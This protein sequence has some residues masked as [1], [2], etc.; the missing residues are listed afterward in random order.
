MTQKT[1]DNISRTEA[2]LFTTLVCGLMFV[3]VDL[4]KAR[5]RHMAFEFKEQALACLTTSLALTIDAA[6]RGC[7]WSERV[8]VWVLSRRSIQGDLSI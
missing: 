7:K 4:D 1:Y 8:Y 2:H 6:D 5:F 3:K